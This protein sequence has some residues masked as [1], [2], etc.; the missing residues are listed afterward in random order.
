MQQHAGEMSMSSQQP[1]QQHIGEMSRPG[2]Q[3][4]MTQDFHGDMRQGGHL[5]M[6]TNE[7]RNAVLHYLRSPDG[8]ITEAERCYTE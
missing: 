8:T 6:Q 2:E 4:M 1:M 7:I 3:A 5:Y